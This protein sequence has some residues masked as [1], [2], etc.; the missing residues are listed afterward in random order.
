[1][2]YVRGLLEPLSGLEELYSD[3][4]YIWTGHRTSAGQASSFSRAGAQ[5]AYK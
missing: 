5:A 1:M 2:G 3:T 4:S